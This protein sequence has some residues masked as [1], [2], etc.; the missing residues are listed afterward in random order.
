MA[1]LTLDKACTC[2][3]LYFQEYKQLARLPKPSKGN[4]R[5]HLCCKSCRNTSRTKHGNLS[6]TEIHHIPAL[7]PF[8]ARIFNPPTSGIPDRFQTSNLAV[9][10]TSIYHYFDYSV[11]ILCYCES[12]YVIMVFYTYHYSTDSL[13]S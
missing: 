2:Y 3:P 5:S 4:S 12:Y 1:F 13:L 7:F 9:R 11:I 8:P 10:N 6:V